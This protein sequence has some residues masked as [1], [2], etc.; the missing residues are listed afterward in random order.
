[1]GKTDGSGKKALHHGT[2]LINVN[3]QNLK[4]YL[5]PNKEKLKSKGVDSVISRVVNLKEIYPDITHELF[6]K[7]VENEFIKHYSNC[8]SKVTHLDSVNNPHVDKIFNEL[9]SWDWLYGNTPN[10]TNELE[11]RFD[12]GIVDIFF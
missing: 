2:M 8:S 10:F 5:N 7:E 1:M 6:C 9:R 12:W 4:N 3:S 11:K